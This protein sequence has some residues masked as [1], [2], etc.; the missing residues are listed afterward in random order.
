MSMTVKTA[1]K[2]LSTTVSLM[3]NMHMTQLVNF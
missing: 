1:Y 3:R 2:T